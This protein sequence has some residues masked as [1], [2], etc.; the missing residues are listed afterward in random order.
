MGCHAWPSRRRGRYCGIARRGVHRGHCAWICGSPRSPSHTR[1][2]DRSGIR[3]FGNITWQVG[4]SPAARPGVRQRSTCPSIASRSRGLRRILGPTC[5]WCIASSDFSMTGM[6]RTEGVHHIRSVARSGWSPKRE[7]SEYKARGSFVS[8]TSWLGR[9]SSRWTRGSAR[10]NFVC[11][12][13]F[14]LGHSQHSSS[15]LP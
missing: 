4:S 14:H 10:P 15:P 1:L 2:F 12:P 9:S 3:P 8:Q 13:I 6:W 11:T 5:S 7:R